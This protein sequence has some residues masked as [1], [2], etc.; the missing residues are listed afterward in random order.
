MSKEIEIKSV[1]IADYY[2]TI[3]AMMSALHA[4]ERLLFEKTADWNEID[5]NYMKHI[6]ERQTADEGVFLIAFADGKSAGFIFG[7]LETPDDSRI[8]I[9]TGKELYVSDGFIYPEYRRQGIYRQ[10][11]KELERIFIAQGIKRITRFTLVNNTGIRQLLEA[12]G[13]TVTRLLYEKWL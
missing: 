8:E 13:Y 6:I 4:N 9:F 11:N 2:D 10:L 1:K 5:R 3:H 12:G 7:Y